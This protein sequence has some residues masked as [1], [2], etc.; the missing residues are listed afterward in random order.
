MYTISVHQALKRDKRCQPSNE[1]S[2]AQVIQ[3]SR[4]TQVSRQLEKTQCKTPAD[5]KQLQKGTTWSPSLGYS[6]QHERD[7]SWDE[8]GRQRNK[9]NKHGRTG[10][11]WEWCIIKTIRQRGKCFTVCEIAQ[12]FFCICELNRQKPPK[13]AQTQKLALSRPLNCFEFLYQP[14]KWMQVK[15]S[16]HYLWRGIKGRTNQY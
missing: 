3:N 2:Q 14:H 4:N 12:C 11:V 10:K 1:C 13:H 16:A 15:C 7:E 9:S 8:V 6:A 5:N